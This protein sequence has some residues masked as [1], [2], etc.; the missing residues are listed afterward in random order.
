MQEKHPEREVITWD[1]IGSF[2][3]VCDALRDGRAVELELSIELHETALSRLLTDEDRQAEP[4]LEIRGGHEL[5]EKLAEMDAFA[6]MAN[7]TENVRDEGYRI[8]VTSAAP[9]IFIEP[10]PE[11][12][13]ARSK[14]AVT[15]PFRTPRTV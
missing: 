7:L 6:P 12:N 4:V 5:L 11:A 15:V 8:A 14:P 3:R 1:E 2:T 10:P 13:E 9:T